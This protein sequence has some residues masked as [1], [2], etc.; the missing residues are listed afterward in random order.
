MIENSWRIQKSLKNCFIVS[1][2]IISIHYDIPFKNKRFESESLL[3]LI[4]QKKFKS[5]NKQDQPAGRDEVDVADVDV[6]DV[7]DVDVVDVDVD[8]DV[9]AD[10]D[11]G[12]VVDDDDDVVTV[13]VDVE[14]EVFIEWS[15]CFVV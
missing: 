10:D 2:R 13:V 5:L 4:L 9:D 7:V 12:V 15:T 6:V 1:N 8:V 14:E 3:S 11:V